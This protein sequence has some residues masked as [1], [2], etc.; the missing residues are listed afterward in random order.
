MADKAPNNSDKLPFIQPDLNLDDSS[1]HLTSSENGDDNVAGQIEDEDEKELNN[2]YQSF[3]IP[4]DMKI[5]T[6]TILQGPL[7]SGIRPLGLSKATYLSGKLDGDHLP[8]HVPS[9][10]KATSSLL[11]NQ[12]MRKE[13][14]RRKNVQ[15]NSKLDFAYLTANPLII[16]G[17][18]GE[19]NK[20]Q[21]LNTAQE[22]E[23]IEAEI[24]S[25]KLKVKY[26]KAIATEENLKRVLEQECS[27]LHLSGHG[28]QH[29]LIFED[30]DKLG[31]AKIIT[32]RALKELLGT[33]GQTSL[34]LVVVSACHSYFAGKAFLDNSIKSVVCVKYDTTVDD[35]AA[36]TFSRSFYNS[37]WSPK[38]HTVKKAFNGAKTC[39]EILQGSQVDKYKL[40]QADV[41][42]KVPQISSIETGELC[43]NLS[44]EQPGNILP[45]NPLRVGR[46]AALRNVLNKLSTTSETR[47]VI[48]HNASKG[49]GKRA[50]ALWLAHY[51]SERST[52]TFRRIFFFE[53]N[54]FPRHNFLHHIWK[55]FIIKQDNWA[56][57]QLKIL[58][59]LKKRSREQDYK[60]DL[61]RK[62][63]SD[64][65]GNQRWL[66]IVDHLS[67]IEPKTLRR[68]Q[69]FLNKLLKAS[70]RIWL[71]ITCKDYGVA[72]SLFEKT[73]H[74]AYHL[75]QLKPDE[76]AELFWE[77]LPTQF[78]PEEFGYYHCKKVMNEI[79]PKLENECYIQLMRG[80]PGL[81]KLEA[82][83]LQGRPPSKEPT[84]LS[85]LD[86]DVR[87]YLKKIVREVEKITRTKR[88]VKSFTKRARKLYAKNTKKQ[89]N[90]NDNITKMEA[91]TK[92]FKWLFLKKC[93]IYWEGSESKNDGLSQE[94]E[95]F[96]NLDSAHKEGLQSVVDEVLTIHSIK[97]MKEFIK[98]ASDKRSCLYVSDKRLRETIMQY[99]KESK[100]N[101]TWVGDNRLREI[102]QH[103]R[104]NWIETKVFNETAR[105]DKKAEKYYVMPTHSCSND[106]VSIATVLLYVKKH[107]ESIGILVER[108]YGEY[109]E[110]YWYVKLYLS[111]QNN[112]E[113][114]HKLINVSLLS[115]EEWKINR[116]SLMEETIP[117]R[118]MYKFKKFSVGKDIPMYKALQQY[119]DQKDPIILYGFITR[120]QTETLLKACQQ[121]TF[122][123]RFSTRK[124]GLVFSV[125]NGKRAKAPYVHLLKAMCNEV[126]EN[127]VKIVHETPNCKY[128]Y[129]DPPPPDDDEKESKVVNYS[130]YAKFYSSGS[131]R[132]CGIPK[133]LVFTK[134]PEKFPA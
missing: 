131:N 107:L 15:S 54:D 30:Q 83:S 108:K 9:K 124:K 73:D 17:K 70:E 32:T 99:T 11:E 6:P 68:L 93:H 130:Q 10:S 50:F 94:M 86:K 98:E 1:V 111:L 122:I 71:L 134:S 85:E 16:Q 4:I 31:E 123:V 100:I 21:V 64:L 87:H 116:S 118:E 109:F 91:N 113:L 40:L 58:H 47:V 51:L 7:N 28:L 75:D 84:F 80:I 104:R 81:I 45:K 24:K 61:P 34:E 23:Q 46:E 66:I 22:W 101:D 12:R 5:P 57:D 38:E 78:A 62:P 44:E 55:A 90:E 69:E 120:Q 43:V 48:V 20:I 52:F 36:L 14:E 92:I 13:Y 114:K 129:I 119:I 127:F 27:V 26:E 3:T 18:G 74:F 115:A 96:I 37:L 79:V 60:E 82:G 65:I 103:Y 132:C 41:D 88:D 8:A 117:K 53:K 25:S 42:H 59:E 2:Q 89:A 56:E 33:T 125:Y 112:T 102:F 110:D 29:K 95:D 49:S 105:M 19:Y 133:E 76:A 63:I 97:R 128:L 35:K 121:S 72:K 77:S 126:L 106:N 67:D 39:I